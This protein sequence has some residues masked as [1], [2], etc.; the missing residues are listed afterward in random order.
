MIFLTENRLRS[1]IIESIILESFTEDKE[2]L[3][4]KY[5]KNDDELRT[6][7]TSLDPKQVRWLTMRW[8]L[9]P[10]FDKGNHQFSDCLDALISYKSREPAIAAKWKNNPA[11]IAAVDEFYTNEGLTK[12]WTSPTDNTMMSVEELLGLVGL[13][14]AKEGKVKVQDDEAPPS[15]Y[16]G[17]VGPWNLWLPK[18]M[19]DSIRICGF[20]PVT[21][22]SHTTWCTCHVEAQNLF[23]GYNGAQKLLI[24]VIRDNPRPYP[25]PAGQFD[26]FSFGFKGGKLIPGRSSAETIDRDNQGTN[27]QIWSEAFGEFKNDIFEM[28]YNAVRDFGG[29]SPSV[30]MPNIAMKDI[31]VLKQALVSLQKDRRIQE[32]TRIAKDAQKSHP[33]A[34]ECIN[35]VAKFLEL[36]SFVPALDAMGSLGDALPDNAKI[37]NL[38]LKNKTN[39]AYINVIEKILYN[40]PIDIENVNAF[41]GMIVAAYG[42]QYTTSANKIRISDLFI[43]IRRSNVVQSNEFLAEFSKFKNPAEEYAAILML[44]RSTNP[45]DIQS[46]LD[47]TLLK[48]RLPE[49]VSIISSNFAMDGKIFKTFLDVSSNKDNDMKF[50]GLSSNLMQQISKNKNVG[51]AVNDLNFW[52]TLSVK[53]S[54][55]LTDMLCVTRDFKLNKDVMRMIIK[56]ANHSVRMSW[57]LINLVTIQGLKNDQMIIDALGEFIDSFDES[58]RSK[59][60]KIL[61]IN[62]RVE[63]SDQSEKNEEEIDYDSLF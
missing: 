14:Y 31:N 42:E 28:M 24:Y 45:D 62:Y 39:K 3:Q 63:Q 44:A 50:A 11:F 13:S 56:K 10:K 26:Y 7:I 52:N 35:Y 48:D 43:N 21:K 36:N 60:A 4:R 37:I 12:Q 16:I 58:V 61:G 2:F 40:Y 27:D 22:K 51:L 6:K 5:G 46:A 55:S 47:E 38:L 9:N 20:D 15:I 8:G 23:Y 1:I 53:T 19:N 30:E 25:D 59:I 57:N 49:V 17:K 54:K 33:W 29:D 41:Y 34:D 32:A 18:A